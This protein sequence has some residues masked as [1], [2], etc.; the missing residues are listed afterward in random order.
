M[1]PRR[2]DLSLSSE[3]HVLEMHHNVARRERCGCHL[4]ILKTTT[5]AIHLRYVIEIGYTHRDFMQY[6][7]FDN[8]IRAWIRRLEEYTRIINNLLGCQGS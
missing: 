4:Y 2:T 6:V 5:S 3:E 1:A 8:N 7:Y